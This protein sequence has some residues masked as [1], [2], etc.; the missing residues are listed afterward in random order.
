[1]T[2]YD[3]GLVV[4]GFSAGYTIC[5]LTKFEPF[6]HTSKCIAL[7]R[8]SY[9]IES[10]KIYRFFSKPLYVDCPFYKHKTKSCNHDGKNTKCQYF[11]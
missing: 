2:Q 3:I 1:M 7:Y 4:A 10:I 8:L 11:T 6:V 9:G 5:K